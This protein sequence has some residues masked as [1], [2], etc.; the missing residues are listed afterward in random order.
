MALE[1]TISGAKEA[2]SETG[3]KRG[4]LF[5]RTDTTSCGFLRVRPGSS[6]FARAAGTQPN[7]AIRESHLPWYT[8]LSLQDQK[9]SSS[10]LPK[11]DLAHGGTLPM[12]LTIYSCMKFSLMISMAAVYSYCHEGSRAILSRSVGCHQVTGTSSPL[13]P[14]RILVQGFPPCLG[15]YVYAV[16]HALYTFR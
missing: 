7:P 8:R 4:M 15:R 6:K 5:P 3:R 11:M 2:R 14:G 1:D 16:F 10:T 13:V 9:T 12:E